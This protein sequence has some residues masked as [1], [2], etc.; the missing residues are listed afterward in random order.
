MLPQTK[1]FKHIY[2]QGDCPICGDNGYGKDRCGIFGNEDLSYISSFSCKEMHSDHPDFEPIETKHH[3]TKYRLRPG[4]DSVAQQVAQLIAR[5]IQLGTGA[6]TSTLGVGTRQKTTQIDNAIPFA[7]KDKDRIYRSILSKTKPSRGGRFNQ[8]ILERPN[9]KPSFIADWLLFDPYTVMGHEQLLLPLTKEEINFIEC[10]LPR[11]IRDTFI[12]KSRQDVS[13]YGLIPMYNFEGKVQGFQQMCWNSI[14]INDPNTTDA[15]YK[16]IKGNTFNGVTYSSKVLMSNRSLQHPLQTLRSHHSCDTLYLVEGS[17]KP[18]ILFDALDHKAHV[19]GAFGGLFMSSS[20]LFCETLLKFLALGV[21]NVVFLVDSDWLDPVKKANVTSTIGN[22]LAFAQEFGF[23]TKV[24][25]K[26]QALGLIADPDEVDPSSIFNDKDYGAKTT[27]GVASQIMVSSGFTNTK[28]LKAIKDKGQKSNII[29]IGFRDID[30]YKEVLNTP[31]S[32][33]FLDLR[34]TGSGKSY[35]VNE[36]AK[37]N[38][39]GRTFYV[40]GSVHGITSKDIIKNFELLQ[41]RHDGLYLQPGRKDAAG[42]GKPLINT[43]KSDIQIRGSNCKR[44]SEFSGL[45][46]AGLRADQICKSCPVYESCRTGTN[47]DGYTFLHDQ[48]VTLQASKIACTVTSFPLGHVKPNDTVF[49]D[50]LHTHFG[51]I[52]KVL[53][54]QNLLTDLNNFKNTHPSTGLDPVRNTNDISMLE[55]K[56]FCTT[57][58]LFGKAREYDDARAYGVQYQLAKGVKSTPYFALVLLLR[59]YERRLVESS[60]SS[61]LLLRVDVKL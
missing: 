25:D 22:T 32:K 54:F 57:P 3:F 23:R 56:W 24:A 6:S 31:D 13:A 38:T 55:F 60:V 48:E 28:K 41:G 36:Y 53:P 52:S 1:S 51:L 34:I 45:R 58:Y 42:L 10:I 21:K 17:L 39:Q 49:I 50:E 16:N 29:N 15:K 4:K 18:L 19:M 40:C 5:S 2:E 11:E 44:F 37:T 61:A 59:L 7:T 27:Q 26:G 47:Q 9:V 43:V 35:S 8:K 20:Q 46:D 33:L 14:R 12:Q 30:Q